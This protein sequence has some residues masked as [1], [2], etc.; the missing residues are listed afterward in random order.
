VYSSSM[1]TLGSLAVA[2]AAGAKVGEVVVANSV[3]VRVADP[4]LTYFCTA[5]TAL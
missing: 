1:T 5:P 2:A 4:D 3:V